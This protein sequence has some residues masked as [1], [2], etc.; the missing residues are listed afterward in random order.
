MTI[1]GQTQAPGSVRNEVEQ[2]LDRL[3]V[4]ALA[5]RTVPFDPG[6]DAHTVVSTS[7]KAPI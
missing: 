5:A 3:G 7:R 2:Y 1:D 6:Y 4:P